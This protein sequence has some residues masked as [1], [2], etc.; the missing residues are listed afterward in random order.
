MEPAKKRGRTTQN[1]AL[2]VSSGAASWF[3]R[4]VT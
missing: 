4:T 1:C 3:I 2:S